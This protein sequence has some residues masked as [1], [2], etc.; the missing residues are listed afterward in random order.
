[1][2][3]QT[4]V[5]L[6]VLG[7]M[8]FKVRVWLCPIVLEDCWVGPHQKGFKQIWIISKSQFVPT[9][10]LFTVLWIPIQRTVRKNT[11]DWKT[12]SKPYVVSRIIL[13]SWVG[14][15]EGHQLIPYHANTRRH[16]DHISPEFLWPSH[17]YEEH[18]DCYCTILHR[19]MRWRR[20]FVSFKQSWVVPFR[21]R[22]LISAKN[23]RDL[24]RTFTWRT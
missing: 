3:G 13:L 19:K 21:H 24:S 20:R 8:S 4:D 16:C 6:I 18:M 5:Y 22:C 12:L 14:P 23:I 9:V 1:M 11:K 10:Y 17:Y 15:K 7:L 2:S